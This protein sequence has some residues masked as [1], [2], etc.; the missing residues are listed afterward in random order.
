[1][2]YA[3]DSYTFTLSLTRP[4]VTI[5]DVTSV[6]SGGSSTN[7]VYSYALVSGPDL[8]L[9]TK[10]TLSGM[11]HSGNNGTF[12]INNLSV[13]VESLG[14]VYGTFSVSNPTAVTGSETGTGSV[15]TAPNVT[16]APIIQIVQ[17]PTLVSMLSSAASMTAID[18]SNQTWMYTWSIGNSTNGEYIAIISYV[19]D[20]VT[21]NGK[22]LEKIKVGDTYV[23]GTVALDA[24]VAKD[25]SVAK[26][27][28]VAHITDLIAINPNTSPVILAIQTSTA[29]L[30]LDP[31]GM[32]LLGPLIQNI[33]DLHDAALGPQVVDKTQNPVLYTIMRADNSVLATYQL[34]DTSTTTSR[35][36]T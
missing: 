13:E 14:I 32:T 11:T 16:T 8:H 24:T 34:S 6:V 10:I 15:G 4:D 5:V 26:D 23:I 18:A 25:A 35:I 20:G 36:P 2:I 31:S 33:Q 17:L 1:M 9:G 29:N 28:T 21:M 27:A 12:Q 30:P 22:M 19:A 3:N 7:S